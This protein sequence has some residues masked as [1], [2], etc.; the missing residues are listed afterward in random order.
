VAARDTGCYQPF[1]QRAL[2]DARR[3]DQ[4]DISDLFRRLRSVLATRLGSIA[5]S[6]PFPIYA[7]AQVAP[8]AVSGFAVTGHARVPAT[9]RCNRE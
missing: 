4:H 2:A 8:V 1:E 6:S 3:A 5:H 7:F 9:L